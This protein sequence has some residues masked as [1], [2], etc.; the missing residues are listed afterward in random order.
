MSIKRTCAI[1]RSAS[2]CRL[3]DILCRAYR[4]ARIRNYREKIECELEVVEYVIFR[5]AWNGHARRARGRKDFNPFCGRMVWSQP[6]AARRATTL[7]PP[8]VS[9]DSRRSNGA[10]SEERRVGKECRYWR[11][12]SSDVCSSDLARRSSANSKSSS[13]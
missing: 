2:G 12:W 3:S 8:A 5:E 7:P 11:D 4:G 6:C 9:Y 1:A 10:R 13:T